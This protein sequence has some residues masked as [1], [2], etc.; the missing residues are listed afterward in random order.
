MGYPSNP[1]C[2]G[3]Q[4]EDVQPYGLPGPTFLDRVILLSEMRPTPFPWPLCPVALGLAHWSSKCLAPSSLQCLLLG[5]LGLGMAYMTGSGEPG[6]IA[7]L[8]ET[9]EAARGGCQGWLPG[10]PARGVYSISAF[11]KQIQTF[12]LNRK[13]L[14]THLGRERPSPTLGP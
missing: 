5:S 14:K 6:Q 4:T 7:G 11:P 13:V 9:R 3:P 1:V 2:P 8:Q 12:Y 10:V